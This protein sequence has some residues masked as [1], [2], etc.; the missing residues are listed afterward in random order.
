MKS[1][2]IAPKTGFG[3]MADHRLSTRFGQA[4]PFA[5]IGTLSR[6]FGMFGTTLGADIHGFGFTHGSFEILQQGG[7]GR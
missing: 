2:E 5:T 7:A 6:P 1:F 3:A 4:I